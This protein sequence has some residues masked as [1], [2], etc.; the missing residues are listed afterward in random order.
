MLVRGGRYHV[1]LVE[2][3][4]LTKKSV[5]KR[6]FRNEAKNKR[7]YAFSCPKE[8][9]ILLCLKKEKVNKIQQLL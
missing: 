4:R 1:E 7:E 3:R 2:G 9:A 8:Y 5:F 6:R